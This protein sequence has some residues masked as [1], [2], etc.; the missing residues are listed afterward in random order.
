MSRRFKFAF[1]LSAALASKGCERRE[2]VA[3][4]KTKSLGELKQAAAEKSTEELEKARKEA[5]WKSDD[6]VLAEA[7]EKYER[8]SKIYIKA[9]LADYRKLLDDIRKDVDALQNEAASWETA[10]D[11]Q[12]AIASFATRA[13]KDK[14]AILGRYDEITSKGTEGGDTQVALAN[15]VQAWEALLGE[16]SADL[17]RKA[18]REARFADVRTKLDEVSKT[19]DE[20]EKD[21]SL[22]TEPDSGSAPKAGSDGKKAG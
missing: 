7:K 12:Q 2:D 5:G 8:D 13:K 22:A 3:P 17:A 10:K 9:R 18:T 1:A 11:P 15:A 6:E 19:L 4:P 20:I 21:A 14:T 16:S